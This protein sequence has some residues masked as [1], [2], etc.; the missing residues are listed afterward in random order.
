LSSSRQN[1]QAEV[2]VKRIYSTLI[3]A[4]AI[5]FPLTGH[6]A[7]TAKD[8]QVAERVLNFLTNPL[9]GTQKLGIVYDPT[10]PTSTADKQSLLAILGNGLSVGGIT[11]VPVPITLDKISST[12]VNALFL[13][14][15]LGSSA[16][17]VGQQKIVCITTDLAATQA[18]YCAVSIQTDPKVQITINKAAASA[19]GISFASA[20]MMMVTEI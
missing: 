2:I 12:P 6:A 4:A 20:F 10:N 11:L 19:S 17:P 14:S 13:T 9:V 3:C 18:G 7:V 15:G 8:I 16:T 5:I 1:Y